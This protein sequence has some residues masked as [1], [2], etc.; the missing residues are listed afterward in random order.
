M[1]LAAIQQDFMTCLLDTGQGGAPDWNSR[2]AQGFEIYRSAYRSR[3]IGALS[4]TFPR[5]ARWVGKE[6]FEAAAAHHLIHHPPCDWTIDSAGRGFDATLADLFGNDPEVAELAW[7]EWT[8][9]LAYVGADAEPLGVAG[10]SAMAACLGEDDWANLRLAFVPTLAFAPAIH[11][12]VSL[13]RALAE[14]SSPEMAE[15]LA[16]PGGCLVWREGLDPVCRMADAVEG[17]MLEMLVTGHTYGEA[18]ARLAAAVGAEE[19]ARRA[20]SILAR[21]LELGLIA[22]AGTSPLTGTGLRYNCP[23]HRF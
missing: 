6:A 1:S 8:M 20:G 2:F 7:L 9:Y 4:E 18:C 13:W 5:T 16:E 19:A 14:P 12:C 21:W 22:D 10:F 11:D 3:L 17:M 15:R 23:E